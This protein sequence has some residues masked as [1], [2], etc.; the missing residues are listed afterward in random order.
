MSTLQT[1]HGL[2]LLAAHRALT[3]QL[4]ELNNLAE[5]G[6]AP[7]SGGQKL[8]PIPSE[9]ILQLTAIIER[10]SSISEQIARRHSPEIFEKE[11]RAQPVS[12]TYRWLALM[13]N[14]M[15]ESLED[16]SPERI[17][18]KFG[19]FLDADENARLQAELDEMMLV[20][21]SAQDLIDDWRKA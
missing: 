1:G 12:A 20:F 15:E 6:K 3:R 18:R 16:L 8:T 19:P 9:Q 17:T 11:A 10:I 4:E 7:G 14:R 5:R 21:K 2:H 13:L